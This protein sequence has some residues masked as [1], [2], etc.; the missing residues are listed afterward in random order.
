[1]YPAT[2]AA[3]IFQVPTYVWGLQHTY[4]VLRIHALEIQSPALDFLALCGQYAIPTCLAVKFAL[5]RRTKL[6]Y[7]LQYS[8]ICFY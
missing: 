2:F 3:S 8:P 4:L 7:V 1:M 5:L 6:F